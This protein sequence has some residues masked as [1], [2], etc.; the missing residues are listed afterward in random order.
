[1]NSVL[2][3]FYR[4]LA[5]FIWSH[6]SCTP[7]SR[8]LHC[9]ESNPTCYFFQLD[10]DYTPFY[11]S[12]CR[13]SSTN[14]LFIFMSVCADP[15][16]YVRAAF[17]VYRLHTFFAFLNSRINYPY[18][19]SLFVTPSCSY[20]LTLFKDK[21]VANL[22]RSCAEYV[23]V[24]MDFTPSHICNRKR[25]HL[26][27]LF[28]HFL[29]NFLIWADFRPSFLFIFVLFTSQFKYEFKN[30]KMLCLGFEPWAAGM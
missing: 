14:S 27:W 24:I 3:N 19:P 13:N 20:I 23:Y 25:C 21:I 16:T 9:I 18:Y 2:G 11:N 17:C 6:C 4:H 15:L 5:I 10:E 29:D 28:Q 7:F 1:M 30:V 26:L 8:R 22:V 12:S